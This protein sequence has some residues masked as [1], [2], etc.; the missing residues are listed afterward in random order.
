V[1]HFPSPPPGLSSPAVSADGDGPT[2]VNPAAPGI[3]PSPRRWGGL[4]LGLGIGVLLTLVGTRL[5][6]RTETPVSES[7]PA[8]QTAIATQTVTVA[9][10]TAATVADTL[11]VNGTVQA[12]DL[13]SVSPQASGLQ[14]QQLLVREGDTVQAGQVLAVLDDAALQADLRQAQAQ[15]TV[16]QT[17]V[18]QRRAA[19]AQ[20]QANVAEARQNLERIQSLA[21]QGAISQ[22]ELTRQQTQ[23]ATS[24]ESVSLAQAEVESAEAGV[25]SQQAAIDRLQTQLSQTTV[26]A[27]VAGVVAERRA[28]VGDVSAPATPIVTLIQ[29]NQ[30]K[31]SAQVPQAQLSQVSP[32]SSV[33]IRSSTDGR[34]QLQGTVQ[35]IDPLVDADTRV[36]VV[37]ITLPPS[38]LL[39][40]GMFLRGDITTGSRQGL[41]IPAAALQPQPDGTTQV[42]VLT[43]GNGVEARTVELGNRIAANGDTAAQ[44]E[45]LQGLQL[46]EQV[47]TSGVG[48]LQDGDVVRVVE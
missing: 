6:G 47:V 18:T 41:T 40:P 39:R 21:D 9:T 30:L 19:L 15:L 16:S 14:I 26:R 27:P 29:N 5:L 7:E 25:R 10:A 46:G 34:I 42:F 11:T 33:A 3:Q 12:T 43:E 13:L 8:D 32:G 38:D 2:P 23:V 31:L 45:I 20:A 36:A 48:F 35:S 22:Q 1:P 44:V 4:L 37:N 28:T 24:Q 17:Q